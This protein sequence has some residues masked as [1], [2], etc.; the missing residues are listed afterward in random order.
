MSSWWLQSILGIPDRL[1]LL[2][3]SLFFSLCL[4]S[5]AYCGRKGVSGKV[6]ESGGKEAIRVHSVQKLEEF[7]RETSAVHDISGSTAW[8][9]ILRWQ[10][11]WDLADRLLRSV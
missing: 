10:H 5:S 3:S 8:L 6:S 11:P 7:C 9:F 2:F 1:F 4:L